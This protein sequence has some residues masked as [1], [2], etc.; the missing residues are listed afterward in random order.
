[1]SKI[2][3]SPELDVIRFEYRDRLIN[4]INENL[5][6]SIL[7]G[8]DFPLVLHFERNEYPLA[9]KLLED[10]GYILDKEHPQDRQG[11]RILG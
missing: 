9:E 1:M 6:Q 5:R 3:R 4:K 7:D 2:L 10:A 11:I 8:Y